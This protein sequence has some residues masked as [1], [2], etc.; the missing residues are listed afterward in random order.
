MLDREP[1]LSKWEKVMELTQLSREVIVATHVRKI[2]RTNPKQEQ[3]WA[4]VVTRDAIVLCDFETKAVCKGWIELG[5][6]QKI[7][8]SPHGDGY[9]ILHIDMTPGTRKEQRN[10]GMCNLLDARVGHLLSVRRA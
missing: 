5:D 8:C 7:T 9:I 1:L 10:K 6:L 3:E 4:L 2:N